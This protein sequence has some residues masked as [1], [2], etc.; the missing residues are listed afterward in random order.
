MKSKNFILL[1]LSSDLIIEA[2]EDGWIAKQAYV[3]GNIEVR[4]DYC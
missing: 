3:D 2:A 1:V 4:A